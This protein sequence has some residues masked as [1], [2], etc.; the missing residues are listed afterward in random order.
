MLKK[1]AFLGL[2]IGFIHVAGLLPSASAETPAGGS[3]ACELTAR[4]GAIELPKEVDP[5]QGQIFKTCSAQQ[6]CPSPFDGPIM[7]TGNVSCQVF[8]YQISCDGTIIDCPC[9]TA[10]SGCDDPLGYCLC[11]SHGNT[12]IFCRSNFC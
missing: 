8:S 2:A 11:R 10:P 1:L 4:T 5:L 9:S 6:T 3:L 7:C 12:F